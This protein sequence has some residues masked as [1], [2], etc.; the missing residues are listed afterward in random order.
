M[1]KFII[2]P[3]LDFMKDAQQD[4]VCYF[5]HIMTYFIYLEENPILRQT[6]LEYDWLIQNIFKVSLL[7]NG[8]QSAI[9]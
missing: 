5:N 2:L 8:N 4:M 9:G 7:I 6:I 3:I 1:R